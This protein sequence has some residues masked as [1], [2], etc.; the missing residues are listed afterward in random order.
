MSLQ[1]TTHLNQTHHPQPRLTRGDKDTPFKSVD[2][3]VANRPLDA[4]AKEPPRSTA[5]TI[6]NKW[7]AL[8]NKRWKLRTHASNRSAMNDAE[9]VLF[10]EAV[11]L[12]LGA[13]KY[14]ARLAL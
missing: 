6:L 5:K 7:R 9:P 8:S 4:T 1:A 2:T 13:K 14:A 12:T 11:S 3:P 10:E